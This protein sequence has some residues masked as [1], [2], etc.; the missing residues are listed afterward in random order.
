MPINLGTFFAKLL[1]IVTSK[2][3]LRIFIVIGVDHQWKDSIINSSSLFQLFDEQLT[4]E[5]LL[6]CVG[7]W[8]KPNK[9]ICLE[10]FETILHDNVGKFRICSTMILTLIQANCVPRL[11]SNDRAR[12]IVYLE[13]FE[14]LFYCEW[15]RVSMDER[16][17]WGA[18]VTVRRL[19]PKPWRTSVENELVWLH[20]TA[21]VNCWE[22]LNIKKVREVF[23][24]ESTPSCGYLLILY[25]IRFSL[26]LILT[27]NEQG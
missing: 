3:Y 24:K 21:K 1:A 12:S 25:E 8:C 16:I 9:S 20:P 18:S 10:A 2:S 27:I 13:D 11:E 22:D 17:C 23:F 7:C 6:I 15:I 19:N 5:S 26:V 14:V 4:G